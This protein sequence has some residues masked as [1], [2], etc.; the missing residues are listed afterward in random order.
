MAIPILG[1]GGESDRLS[2]KLSTCTRKHINN[3][4]PI[5]IAPASLRASIEIDKST[6]PQARLTSTPTVTY[7][8]MGLVF[9][10]RRTCIDISE[11]DFILHEDGY[12]RL[13]GLHEAHPGDVVGYRKDG[14]VEHVGLINSTEVNYQ[15]LP[16]Q[17]TVISKWGRHAEYLHN[18]KDVPPQ[19]GS[20]ELFWTHR[21]LPP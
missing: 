1:A 19:Y 5:E 10:S 21:K 14:Q 17:A 13:G 2:L 4:R 8:C 3:E 9:A 16:I 20:P 7:N 18:I 12:R 6:N 15:G 11:L